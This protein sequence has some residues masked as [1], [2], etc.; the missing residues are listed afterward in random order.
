MQTSQQVSQYMVPALGALYERYQRL[1][2][3][4]FRVTFGAFFIPHGFQKLFGWW[5]GNI[6]NTAKTMAAN[7]LEPGLFW[8]YYIGVLEVVGGILLV[9]GLLTRPVAAL[10]FGF[11]AV[12][13]FHVHMK[14]AYFWTARGM[15]MPLLLMLLALVFMIRGGGEYSLDRRIGREL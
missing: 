13:A 1:A 14:I 6:A 5:G 9:L 11:L 12:G 7:S 4:I 8:A 10:F 3:P 15:E 2:W